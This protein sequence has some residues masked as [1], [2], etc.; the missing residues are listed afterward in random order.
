MVVLTNISP[1]HAPSRAAALRRLLPLPVV[2]LF[3]RQD[4][5]LHGP[6]VLAGTLG[7]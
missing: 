5:L 6:P 7:L 1:V 3:S 4:Q 2:D